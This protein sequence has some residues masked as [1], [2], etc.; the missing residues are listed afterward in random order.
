MSSILFVS[1]SVDVTSNFCSGSSA[2]NAV[3]NGGALI[4]KL[5]SI[6]AGGNAEDPI[7]LAALLSP[8]AGL[9]V[10]ITNLTASDDN[11]PAGYS[12]GDTVTVRFSQATNTPLAATKT[13]IDSLFTIAPGPIGGNYTGVYRDPSTLVITTGKPAATLIVKFARPTIAESSAVWQ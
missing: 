11:L 6:V 3:I 10:V 9:P 7:V 2:I 12:Q 5:P 1:S 4:A 8:A 13:Q